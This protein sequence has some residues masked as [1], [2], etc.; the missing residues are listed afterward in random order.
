VIHGG[1]WGNARIYCILPNSN[2]FL[3]GPI[4]DMTK[5]ILMSFTQTFNGMTFDLLQSGINISAGIDPIYYDPRD[6]AQ[7]L[8]SSPVL[9]SLSADFNENGIIY[10]SG[11][12]GN[13]VI[14]SGYN[15]RYSIDA[16]AGND[17]IIAT[18]SFVENFIYGGLGDDSISGSLYNDTILG[19][20]GDDTI[21]TFGGGGVTDGGAGNDIIYTTSHSGVSDDYA[22]GG[23]GADVLVG[24]G[25]GRDYLFG[26]AGN[27]SISG[28]LGND[29]LNGGTGNDTI[30]GGAGDDI[31]NGGADDDRIFGGTDND[32]LY[33]DDGLDLLIGGAGW[34]VLNGGAGADIFGFRGDI[35]ADPVTNAPIS[36]REYILDFEAG[37]DRIRIDSG[38]V[39][40]NYVDFDAMTSFYNEGNWGVIEF[41]NGNVIA[42]WQTDIAQVNAS[43]FEFAFV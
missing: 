11:S 21:Y 5:E 37:V 17:S 23:D 39:A 32:M 4:L 18:S 38:M 26:D 6:I 41:A 24:Q 16:G 12:N 8:A 9:I 15:I 30:N 42:L 19:G 14:Y 20:D 29:V 10:F 43:W 3:K 36:D 40:S 33:G 22:S 13:D 27:D 2:A 28:E 31:L 34:D 25:T 1:G 7:Y 35:S